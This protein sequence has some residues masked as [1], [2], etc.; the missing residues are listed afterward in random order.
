MAK[1]RFKNFVGQLHLWLG[2]ASGIIVFMLGITGCILAFEVEIKEWWYADRLFVASEPNEQPLPLSQSLAAAQREMGVDIGVQRLL[3]P[4]DPD[5]SVVAVNYT[6]TGVPKSDG[7][8]Y[9]DGIERYLHVYV[10][11]Y[12]AQVLGQ[13]DEKFDFFYFV[14]WLH[15]SL[16]L[17]TDLGKHIIGTA[18]LIFVILLITGLV[19]W[20]PKTKKALKMNTWFRWKPTTKWKRK[21][22]DLHNIVG[23]Y[24]MFLV[25]F[26]ALTGL[27]WAFA[28]FDNGVQ[29]MANGGQ[30]IE[31]ERPTIESTITT[32]GGVQQPLDIIHHSLKTDYAEAEMYYI[33]LPHDSAG[34]I[35]GY[36]KY[37]DRT[38]N[39]NLQFDQYSG[40]LLHT[41]NR[42]ADKTGG[43]KVWAY[44]YD[45]HTG[46]IGGIVGKTIAFFLSLFAASFPVTGTYIWWV[47]YQNKRRAE[48]KRRERERRKS[49][50]GRERPGYQLQTTPEEGKVPE[51][52][53]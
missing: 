47:K 49:T 7:V 31:K 52:V 40:A 28:W 21:N 48:R 33:N 26:I 2:L 24:S 18:T 17:R 29:W 25:I 1:S 50:R 30:T 6:D 39:V 8:W 10:D 43:E 20:W 22:Y 5:R 46:A 12:T 14:E 42:W 44:N 16:L 11:P 32:S 35:N 34:T 38:K 9:W 23:F 45:V 41:A 36:V 27:M 51:T 3:V 15:Y 53:R 19:L 4:G 13:H 37:A